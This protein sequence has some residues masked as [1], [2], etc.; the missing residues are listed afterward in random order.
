MA[1]KVG[2]LDCCG[3]E[4]TL[5]LPPGGMMVL[6]TDNTHGFGS[7]AC[8]GIVSVWRARVFSRLLAEGRLHEQL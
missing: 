1:S 2:V 5:V 7:F 8:I 4:E 3:L 6:E